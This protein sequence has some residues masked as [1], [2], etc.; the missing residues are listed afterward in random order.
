[1]WQVL[2][3]MKEWIDVDLMLTNKNLDWWNQNWAAENDR[4]HRSHVCVCSKAVNTLRANYI[5]CQSILC[6]FKVYPPYKTHAGHTS[7]PGVIAVCSARSTSVPACAGTAGR[8]RLPNKKRK[9][10]ESLKCQQIYE[11][12]LRYK[13]HSC[14]G[15][16]PPTALPCVALQSLSTYSCGTPFL[17]THP[18][19]GPEETQILPHPKVHYL[20]SIS[21]WSGKSEGLLLLKI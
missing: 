2:W 18:L 4:N 7:I 13:L 3:I 21:W 12:V 10:S 1:M 9:D 6:E 15:W 14:S 20:I 11:V 8:K 16:K 5:A 17:P 19:R